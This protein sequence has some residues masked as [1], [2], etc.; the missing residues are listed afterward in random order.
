MGPNL[1]VHAALH[2]RWEHQARHNYELPIMGCVASANRD[3]AAFGATFV[4]IDC[5]A[6]EHLYNPIY[7]SP[8]STRSYR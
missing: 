3:S 7:D 6:I 5:T 1:D 8:R 4:Y 2:F